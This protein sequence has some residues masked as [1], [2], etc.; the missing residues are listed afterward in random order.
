MAITDGLQNKFKK[1]FAQSLQDTLNPISDDNYFLFFG[2]ST[3]WTE[4]TT[5]PA[6][7]DSVSD[8]FSALRNGLF[9]VRIDER[10]SMLVVPRIDWTSG[11]IYEEYDDAVDLHDIASRKNYYVLVDGDKVYKCISNASGRLST[12]KPELETTAIFTTQEGYQW[13]FLYKLTEN[14]KDFLT[15]EYL[16]VVIANKTGDEV[17]QKQ[18]DVQQN[19]IDGG[20]YRISVTSSGDAY[21]NSVST[22]FSPKIGSKSSENKYITVTEDFPRET[23][24]YKDYM[25]YVSSGIGNE[26]GQLVRIA[27]YAEDTVTGD[28]RIQ[29][30]T[31]LETEVFGRDDANSRK[32]FCQILPEILIHG[33]GTQAKG[34]VLVDSNKKASS[35]KILNAGRDYT[36]AYASFPTPNGGSAPS[37]TVDIPPKGG[38]GANVINE[39]DTSRLMIRLLNENV[40]N[41]PA[42]VNVNDYRQYGIIKNPILNDNSLRVAG[43]EYNRKVNVE[44]SRPHGVSL[45]DYFESSSPSSTFKVGEFVYGFE[46]KSVATISSWK[47]NSDRKSGTL[48]LDNPSKKFL[49]PNTEQKL[50]RANFGLSGASGDYTLF[51]KVQQFQTSGVT[52]EGIVQGWNSSEKE[53]LIRITG[54]GESGSLSFANN[55]YPIVGSSSNAYHYDFSTLTEAGGELIGTFG[56]TS[57]T[58][59]KLQDNTKI[60]RIS[61]G[62][63]AFINSSETPI[64]KMNS[65]M[66]VTGSGFNSGTFTL[67]EGITQEN[68]RIFSTA[69]VVSWTPGSGST[70]SLVL[71]N[72]IGNF[73][74]GSTIEK[75][76][77]SAFTVTSITEPDLVKGSG[78]VLYIQNIRPILRQ[79]KQREEFRISIGF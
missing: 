75:A 13:K 73:T 10:N 63:N 51:E 20:L 28:W 69:N 6:V 77:G 22:E 48:I 54:T 44:I 39:L 1:Q 70:G 41:Q 50:V 68:N 53:L 29:L 43:S 38:H 34:V 18:Y 61:R 4:E 19:A 3:A 67:D 71:S 5:P 36:T 11:T 47:V 78:E 66:V 17:E 56:T 26:V 37:V 23:N 16:P 49:L 21:P 58:F 45:S 55:Q 24:L 2:K 62:S 74:A 27:G 57:G 15:K 72:V 12:D 64:Y 7:V 8:H 79:Q 60:A 33:D 30:E 9:A 65:S 52:A 25:L 42:I 40:E 14:Q 76:S 35:I 31:P 32:S 59:K 46:S